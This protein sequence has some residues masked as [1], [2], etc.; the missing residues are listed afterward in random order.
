MTTPIKIN[1]FAALEEKIPK[2]P[3]IWTSVD[4]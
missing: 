1:K 4:I 2:Y 3:E